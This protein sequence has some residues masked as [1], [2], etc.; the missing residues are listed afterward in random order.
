MRPSSPRSRWCDGQ[1]GM[2]PGCTSFL[3]VP[4]NPQCIPLDTPNPIDCTN[5]AAILAAAEEA[6]AYFAQLG[7]PGFVAP[8]VCT[9]RLCA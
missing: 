1:V 7:P 2:S 3:W 6:L 9:R 5:L 8:I 4:S